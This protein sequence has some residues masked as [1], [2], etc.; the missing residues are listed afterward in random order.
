MQAI[1]LGACGVLWQQNLMLGSWVLLG[2]QS[3]CRTF[4]SF[5]VVCVKLPHNCVEIIH[6]G[7]SIANR[8]PFFRT[9]TPRVVKN[10][11][12]FGLNL[13]RPCFKLWIPEFVIGKTAILTWD[14]Q[15]WSFAWTCRSFNG[16]LALIDLLFS[17]WH[18]SV[19][20]V[21]AY[22]RKIPTWTDVVLLLLHVLPLQW[23]LSLAFLRRTFTL[24][25]NFH[26]FRGLEQINRFIPSNNSFV[27]LGYLLNPL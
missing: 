22:K 15:V 16:W 4:V 20:S 7:V 27:L 6:S 18:F 24:F 9:L 21:S 3:H 19:D 26:H 14:E 1:L 2:D 25:R 8:G 23:E 10:A 13:S 11:I 5:L 12:E 17:F